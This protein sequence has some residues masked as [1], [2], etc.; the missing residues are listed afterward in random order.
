MRNAEIDE[1]DIEE[2]RIVIVNAPDPFTGMYGLM[3]RHFDGKPPPR[4]WWTLS[5]APFDHRLTRTAERTMELEIVNGQMMTGTFERLFRSAPRP[6]RPGDAQDLAGLVVTVLDV[7]DQGPTRIRLEFAEPP[8][9]DVYQII[10]FQD[11]AFRRL[12]PPP[13]AESVTIPFRFP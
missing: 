3:L 10:A 7:A 12:I 9:S 4:A 8:E 6:L 11:R 2:R 1:T 13:I 5:I